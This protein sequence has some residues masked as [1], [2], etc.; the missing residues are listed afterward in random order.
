MDTLGVVLHT[1]VATTHQIYVVALI[2]IQV[3]HHVSTLRYVDGKINIQ[4]R[5]CRT[6]NYR[7][8]RIAEVGKL[9][10]LFQTVIS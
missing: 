3:A 10:Q 5:W 1:Q 8:G 2:Y 6:R 4:A 7:G 9:N